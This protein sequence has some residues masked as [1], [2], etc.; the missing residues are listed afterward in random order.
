MQKKHRFS[1]INLR[2]SLEIVGINELN[3]WHITFT[4][5][6]PSDYYLETIQR[7][8]SHFDLSLSESAKSLLIDA[9]LLEAIDEFSQ[10]KIWKEAPL[11]TESLTGVVDYLIAQQGKVY[12][13]P[14][15]CVVEA[16]KDDFEQGLAQCLTEM[17]AC[18]L[19]NQPHDSFPI[20]GIITN[21]SMWRFYQL[22]PDKI[23]YESAVYSETQLSD[24]LGILTHLF[25]CCE[26]HLL[27][28]SS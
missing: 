9:I 15:L 22:T 12:Q 13:A 2:H 25:S 8:K 27:K 18:Q 16:K 24:I 28:E 19:F 6:Q 23:C 4:Q 21:A 26:Q 5:K 1:Q 17:Y 20:Y 14:L 11:K 10:L 3:E 7:L